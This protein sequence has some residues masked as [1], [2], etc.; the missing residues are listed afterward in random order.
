[1]YIYTDDNILYFLASYQIC[2][3]ILGY[4]VYSGIA[5]PYGIHSRSGVVC[6]LRSSRK[7]LGGAFKPAETARKGRSLGTQRP[8]TK[9]NRSETWLKTMQ[10]HA[11]AMET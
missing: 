5:A 1:M 9:G 2:P 6:Q 10:K 8:K 11:K 7:G 3:Y 4:T